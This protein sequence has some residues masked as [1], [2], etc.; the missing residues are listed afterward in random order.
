M[1]G[2]SI[3]VG[4]LSCWSQAMSWVEAEECSFYLENGRE[5]EQSCTRMVVTRYG[6]P[7]YITE[8]SRSHTSDPIDSKNIVQDQLVCYCDICHPSPRQADVFICLISMRSISNSPI[9]FLV[10]LMAIVSCL[11]YWRQTH[12]HKCISNCQIWIQIMRLLSM[13]RDDERSSLASSWGSNTARRAYLVSIT[14]VCLLV[15][16]V[17]DFC[18]L[19]MMQFSVG[20]PGAP[21]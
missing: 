17:Y 4:N 10:D 3:E 5:E 18:D 16:L 11:S 8:L 13:Q 2:S 9:E 6:L 15:L 7:L 21:N 12:L 19:R 1:D 20:A 14:G